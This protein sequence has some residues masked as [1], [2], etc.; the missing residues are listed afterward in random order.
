MMSSAGLREFKMVEWATWLAAPTYEELQ[1]AYPHAA[2]AAE[3]SGHVVLR[4][5]FSAK[6]SLDDC[7]TVTEQPAFQGFGGAARSLTAKFQLQ[8]RNTDPRNLRSLRVVLPFDFGPST[9]SRRYI[10]EPDWT[11]QIDP[12]KAPGIY[13]DPA[14]KAGIS[15]G[16][17]VVDCAIGDDGGLNACEAITESPVGLDFGKSAVLTAQAMA[18][19][20][21]TRDGLP[22]P[23]GH[24]KLPITLVYAGD[25]AAGASAAQ[26]APHL[27][28]TEPHS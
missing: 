13:P 8:M 2:L 26:A 22:T 7:D 1:H 20:L 24:I 25:R 17:A 27:T 14:V 10:S 5:G 6:G 16:H 3:R 15:R 12:A 11:R 28:S 4:C 23:G 19:N 21:W 9:S 18:V